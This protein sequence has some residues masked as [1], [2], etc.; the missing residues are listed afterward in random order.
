LIG[1][2]QVE[3]GEHAR[4][5][6]ALLQQRE[7]ELEEEVQA[8]RAA[9]DGA[10]FKLQ[11]ERVRPLLRYHLVDLIEWAMAMGSSPY[12][13]MTCRFLLFTVTQTMRNAPAKRG[14]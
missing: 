13:S 10:D 11:R 1:A 8:A 7:R 2:G 12:A 3:N 6:L 5:M 4:K 14:C 9:A